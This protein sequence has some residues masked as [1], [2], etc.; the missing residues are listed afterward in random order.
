MIPAGTVWQPY[1]T[2]LNQA[3]TLWYHP[4][5]HEMTQTQITKGVGGFIIV[6]DPQETA[7]NLPRTYGV[8]DM[9]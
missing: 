2:V 3:S 7:L 1:W 5:L 9:F 6:K 8:D 4:H